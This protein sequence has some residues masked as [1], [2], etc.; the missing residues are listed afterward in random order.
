[1]VSTVFIRDRNLRRA[2]RAMEAGLR[3]PAPVYGRAARHM[4]DYVRHTITLQGRRKSYTALSAWTRAKTGRRKALITLRPRIK[5]RWDKSKG[6]VYFAPASSSWHIDQHHTG[7]TSPAVTN[8]RMVVPLKAGGVR[9]FWSRKAS[10]IPAREVWPTRREVE[11]EVTPFFASWV[12]K[13][14]R[15]RWR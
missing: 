14:A 8:K 6:E 11:R 15:S 2:M 3:N 9:V 10:K 5:A 4:R 13:L 1:M 7:F 12:D